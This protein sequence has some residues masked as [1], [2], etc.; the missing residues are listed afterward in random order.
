LLSQAIIT[1]VRREGKREKNQ[2]SSKGKQKVRKERCNSAQRIQKKQATKRSRKAK[3]Q[4]QAV[5]GKF[6]VLGVQK[7]SQLFEKKR[8]IPLDKNAKQPMMWREVVGSGW[9]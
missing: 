8:M 4:A 7:N 5:V 9:R 2:E 3:S 1:R 6:R